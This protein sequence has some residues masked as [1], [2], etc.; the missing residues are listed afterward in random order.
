MK[1]CRTLVFLISLPRS[2]RRPAFDTA[3]SGARQMERGVRN[4]LKNRKKSA[5]PAGEPAPAEGG[6]SSNVTGSG[7]VRIK[8][9]ES[10]PF[11]DTPEAGSGRSQEAA[12]CC[13]AALASRPERTAVKTKDAFLQRQPPS[14]QT[15]VQGWREFAQEQGRA[16]VRKRAGQP[17]P[18]GPRSSGTEMGRPMPRSA[19]PPKRTVSKL[20]RPGKPDAR[21]AARRAVKTAENSSRKTIKTAQGMAKAVRRAGAGAAVQSAMRREAIRD[22]GRAARGTRTAARTAS[23]AISAI[24]RA[25]GTVVKAAVTAAQAPFAIA[26]GGVVVFLIVVVMCLAGALAESPLGIFFSGGSGG[27]P[28]AVTPS[29]A[30]AQINS[31]L[32]DQLVQLQ[33][34]GTYDRVELQGRPPAWSDVLAV[35]A[36]RTAE[37]EDG[38]AVAVLDPER[39]ELLQEVF[40]DMTKITTASETV[41][42]PA[43]GSAPASTEEVLTITITARTPDDMRVFYSFSRTK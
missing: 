11:P 19:A 2:C 1:G 36:V 16:L 17:S 22:A 5:Q 33:K 15:A 4:L 34:G 35:F 26:A 40:W 42:I 27:T 41:D 18:P 32:A 21:R 3:A 29:E 6:S 9:Q 13:G 38:S 43:S 24:G 10:R 25:S 14:A 39:V 20:V 31:E 23:A 37:A 30:A 12:N 8:T 28:E 7:R